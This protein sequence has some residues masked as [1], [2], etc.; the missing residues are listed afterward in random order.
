MATTD[1]PRI[2]F[3]QRTPLTFAEV[4]QSHHTR[5]MVRTTI[6]F[7]IVGVVDKGA[8]DLFVP[9]VVGWLALSFLAI[10]RVRGAVSF[11][12]WNVV[13]LLADS[14]LDILAMGTHLPS[15][16]STPFVVPWGESSIAQLGVI[17]Y[18]VLLW[19]IAMPNRALA[20]LD[21]IDSIGEA[22][23]VLM[24]L[25]VIGLHVTFVEDVVYF[26]I[27]G[28][29]PFVAAPPE[30]YVYLPHLPGMPVWSATSVWI[31]ATIGTAFFVVAMV[32]AILDERRRRQQTTH[33]TTESDDAV[34][35]QK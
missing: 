6:A 12:L 25:A 18:W 11:A 17:A 10:S 2:S 28:Y 27:L 13:L 20:M 3:A 29:P 23:R 33:E 31:A 30:N 24:L 8:F 19:G 7:T 34:R 21:R 1:T 15:W 35:A 32:I 22:S 4:A 5:N 14:V 16:M 9:V 26:A